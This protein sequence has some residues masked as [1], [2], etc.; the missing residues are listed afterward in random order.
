[1]KVTTHGEY[2]IRITPFFP[3]NCYL[4]REDDGFTLVDALLPN[5][6]DGILQAAQEAGSPIRRIV[7]THAHMDHVGAVDELVQRLPDAEFLVS[8]RS[9][10]FLRGDMSLD[11]DEPQVKLRGGYRTC[12][13]TPTHELN[14]G[15]TV[16]SL[17]VV[18]APGHTPGQIALLDAR[19][20]TLITADAITTQSGVAVSGKIVWLFPLPAFAT[21]HKPTALDT[22]CRL[23]DLEPSRLATGH[24]PVVEN[25]LARLDRAIQAAARSFS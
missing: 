20:Q 9:A 16:G 18:A 12:E 11:P 17:Q 8:A 2:L 14:D 10:R 6:A 19:D 21:W 25:P 4:V 3:V 7:L 1:M 13:A 22:A 23:R 15:D 24:G 5:S